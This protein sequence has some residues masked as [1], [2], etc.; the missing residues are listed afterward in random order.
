MGSPL[1]DQTG[2]PAEHGRAVFGVLVD[3]VANVVGDAL[4]DDVT[5]AAQA[6]WS[7]I[8]GAVTIEQIGIGQTPDYTVT[9]ER[10]LDL[11]VDGLRV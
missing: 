3:L 5:E 2:V 8:H 1:S 4:A 7:A 6:V 10:T 11:L 9:F